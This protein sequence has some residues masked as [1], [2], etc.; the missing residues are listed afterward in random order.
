MTGSPSGTSAPEPGDRA[1]VT[2][3]LRPGIE[4]APHAMVLVDRVGSIVLVNSAAVR[5]FGHDHAALQTLGVEDLIPERFRSQHPVLRGEFRGNLIPRPLGEG[6]ELIALRADGTEVPV[7]IGINSIETDGETFYLASVIDM[8]SR[9]AARALAEDELRRSILDSIPF[10]V[11]ATDREG[12]VV[13]ANPGAE[14]LLGRRGTT[15]V[16]Q[17]LSDAEDPAHH[18]AGSLAELLAARAGH[19]RETAYVRADGSTVPVLEAVSE[20]RAED[21]HVTGYL[22]VAYDITSRKQAQDEVRRMTTH[23][24]L[25]NLPNR[26]LLERRLGAAIAHALD[27]GHQGA[28]LLLDLDH[29]KTVNDSLGH[30]VGDLVLVEVAER[31]RRWADEQDLVCRFGGDE[32]VVVLNDATALPAVS[33]T[34]FDE[35]TGPMHILEHELA[36]TFSVGGAFFPLHGS[37]PAEVIQHA[38]TAMY[39]AKA[40]GRNQL[41]WFEAGMRAESNERMSLASALRLALREEEFTVAY[42]PQVE[43]STGLT[44]GFEALARWN[45]ATLG[46]VTPDRFIPVAEE[47]GMIV[48]LGAWIL[49]RACQDMARIQAELGRPV[50]LAVNV[51]P[52]QFRS[53]GWVDTVVS[54]LQR[55]GLEPDQLEL[56]ITEGVLMDERWQVIDILSS[57]RE[58]GVRIAID[59]FGLGYSSLAYLTR[60]PIDKLKI[61]RAFVQDLQPHR[62]RAPIIDAIVVLAHA[63][64]MEVVAE[65]V[66]TPGQQDYLRSRGCDEAQGFLYSAAVAP[67]LAFRAAGGM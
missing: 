1:Q 63:L 43:L 26:V 29:F 8:T 22:A 27:S 65:G 28:L 4:A 16:D 59:D 49:E 62:S 23:D 67:N 42:Q 14:Q 34:L 37:D 51:S 41:Q 19:E 15:L 11:L 46:T 64:G 52:R 12:V 31:L 50:R 47:T 25:T 30:H 24:A 10:S 33:A 2:H 7:E 53:E 35:L 61:D 55:S 58:H 5:L 13:A 57:L 3:R 39:H 54:T 66:E 60:F 6:P 56:E 38:D 48:E 21:G 32:F 45:S 44:V 20:L 17:L 40:A 9:V 36:T 18:E